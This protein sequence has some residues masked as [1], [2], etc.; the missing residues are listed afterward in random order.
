MTFKSVH[1]SLPV[2]KID[3]KKTLFLKVSERCAALLAGHGC[4]VFLPT[5]EQLRAVAVSRG[6]ATP[7]GVPGGSLLG[8][9]RTSH[10][11]AC[12]A[13]PPGNAWQG[14]PGLCTS[15]GSVTDWQT[16]FLGSS[17]LEDVKNAAHGVRAAFSEGSEGLVVSSP[18]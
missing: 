1:S 8:Q 17:T 18:I 12:L 9:A 11:R 14:G 7:S 16:A 10:T 6:T 4:C 15:K 13:F 2:A 5:Q 3:K